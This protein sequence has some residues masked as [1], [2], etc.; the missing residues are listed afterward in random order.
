V[1]K[2]LSLSLDRDLLCEYIMEGYAPATSYTPKMGDYEPNA[3]LGF[4]PEKARQLLAE[5]GYPEGKGFPRFSMLISRPAARAGAEA[6]Q[7]MWKEHLGILVDIQNM[8]WGSYNS[9]QQSLDFDMSSAGWIGDYLDPTTFLNMWTEGNGNNNTGWHS[10]QF[11]TLIDQAALQAD[12]QAR[13]D[14]LKQA[15]DILMEDQPILPVSWYSRNYL[16]HPSVKGWHPLLLDNHPWK[17]L[18]LDP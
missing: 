16:L 15:E 5:A 9:A 10:D 8:D 17:A 1:R 3:V 11:E 7:A 4:D 6:L 12:P 2:A 14:M 13:L 18:R